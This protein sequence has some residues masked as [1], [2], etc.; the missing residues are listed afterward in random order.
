M[1]G[2]RRMRQGIA[3]YGLAVL[4]LGLATPALR[5]ALTSSAATWFHLRA[6]APQPVSNH[7][8]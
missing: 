7:R 3:C 4:L 1:K 6:T 8:N 2:S 5:A